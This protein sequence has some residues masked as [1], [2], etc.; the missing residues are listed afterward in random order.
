MAVRRHSAVLFGRAPRT[1]ALL[2]ALAITMAG[3]TATPAPA[4]AQ[5]KKEPAK[6]TPARDLPGLAS[7]PAPKPAS[8]V[9]AA[10]FSTAPPRA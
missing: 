5:A 1:G 6:T 9:P 3:M 10:N 7:Q 8:D 4:G 2:V